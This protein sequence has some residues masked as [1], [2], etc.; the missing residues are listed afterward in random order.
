MKKLAL[1][2]VLLSSTAWAQSVKESEEDYYPL[3]KIPVPPGVVLEAG[4]IELMPDGK[5]AVSTRRGEIWMID[6][7]F[8]SPP[9]N[10]KFTLFASGLHEV[11][12]LSYHDGWL[13]AQQRGELTKLK[14]TD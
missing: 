4:G 10:T 9:A 8:E 2:F 12:G 5:V 6:K 11:L 1:A 7:A 14:D 3:I 13:Y